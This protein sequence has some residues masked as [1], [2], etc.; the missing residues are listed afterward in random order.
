MYTEYY[1]LSRKPFQ[2][3][4]DPLFLFQSKSHSEVL[5]SLVYG[6]RAA[7]G[8]I[9]VVGDIGTGK[10]TLIHALLAGLDPS[11]ITLKITNPRLAFTQSTIGSIL[12]YF[13]KELGISDKNADGREI[14]E[15]ITRELEEK[16]KEGQ[17]AVLIIDEAHL[18][19]EESLHDIRLLSNIEN[20]KR[21][22]IQIVLTGQTELQ[23]KLQE[24]SLR[25]F[26]QW[27]WEPLKI[28]TVPTS[29]TEKL[30]SA[31]ALEIAVPSPVMP[32]QGGTAHHKPS[33]RQTGL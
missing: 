12:K 20:E 7:K 2:N 25:S 13:A 30:L 15:V 26:K 29:S 3:T 9:V 33:I 8:L 24:D 32:R 17:R 28:L 11:Y 22:L 27:I 5:A 18:L 16:D 31:A 21:K 6:I 1:G 23:R 14:I 19:T 10:T 4:S